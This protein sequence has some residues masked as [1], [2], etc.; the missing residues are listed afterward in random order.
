MTSITI[1]KPITKSLPSCIR[2]KGHTCKRSSIMRSRQIFNLPILPLA[3]RMIPPLQFAHKRHSPRYHN[4]S[5]AFRHALGFLP[6][7]AA[8]LPTA[9]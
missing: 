2:T 3:F 5:R 6:D 1:Y 7:H 8:K 4:V 9:Q